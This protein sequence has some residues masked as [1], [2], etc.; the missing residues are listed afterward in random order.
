MRGLRTK[1]DTLFLAVADSEYDV[2]V[3]TETWLDNQILST[4]LFGDSYAVF[5]TDRNPLN[6][7]KLRGGG[8]LIAVSS[9]LCCS[10]EPSQVSDTLEQ[11]W[12]RIKL[13]TCSVSVGVVYIPPDRKDDLSLIQRH[14]DSVSSVLANLKPHDFAFL[15]GDYNHPNMHW[16]TS[17]DGG[18]RSDASL[19]RFSISDSALYD[20]ISFNGLTQINSIKNASARILDL[21]LVNDTA[22]PNCNIA[23]AVESL[24][25]P[26]IAHPALDVVVSLDVPIRFEQ[27]QEIPR[28]DF[29][30]VDYDMMS[31]V[32]SAIDW[33]FLQ[34]DQ[35]MDDIVEHFNSEIRRIIEANVP[36]ERPV[37]KPPWTNN[38]LRKLKRRRRAALRKYKRS[39][40]QQL[41]RNFVVASNKYTSYNRLMY[42]RYVD[43][44]QRNLRSH[45][46]S[47]WSFV[48]SKRKENGLPSSMFLGTLSASTDA[49]KCEL[50]ADR[51]KSAFADVSTSSSQLEAAI[52]DTPADRFDFSIFRITED[53]VQNALRKLKHSTSYGSDGI[54]ACLL[55]KCSNVLARPLATLFNVSLHQ[56][57]F[58]SAWKTSVMTPIHK[59]G[60]KCDMAN[61]R[62]ITSLCAC[63]KL[64]EIIVNDA[65]FAASK[66]YISTAQHGFFPQRSV[67]T[68]LAEFTSVCIRSMDAGMQVDA[69]YTDFKAAFDRVNHAILLR[70]LEKLGVSVAFVGWF[71]SYLSGR[72]IRV[73][74]GSSQSTAF[75]VTS[76]VPQGSNLGP[77]LFSLFINDAAFV[78][79]T[80]TRVFYADDVKIYMI[81][82][83]IED[84]IRLQSLLDS[85]DDWSKRNLLE[86]SVTKCNTITFCRKRQPIV[87]SYCLDGHILE[88][89]YQVRDLGVTLDS[90]LNFRAHYEDII[91]KAN[92]Q[93]GF[94]FKLADG[95]RDPLCL[96]SLYCALVRSILESAVLVWCPYNRIWVDRLES[97]Q[98][99]FVRLALR[100]LPWR[101]RHN[102]P[103]YEHRCMLI[104]IETL[105]KRRSDMQA[106][107]VAKILSN[108][109]D[110]P[111]ILADIAVY[112]PERSLRRRNLLYLAPRNS[113]YGQHD[114]IRFMASRFNEVSHHFDFHVPAHDLL[115]HL[116]NQP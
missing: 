39:G 75:P 23:Q 41:K 33:Q 98:R 53:H 1:I 5:R 88:R 16:T 28:F 2:I 112:V 89:L 107:F 40:S 11:I 10:A 97:V 100:H 76:G 65:L 80:G 116:R 51:F 30:R 105:E 44:T 63:S 92:R 34:D 58:P 111:A 62:G 77:L 14:C 6:S 68:N 37:L 4:Q 17:E 20:V 113:R 31:E 9:R 99:R 12:V 56:M 55:K 81:I 46:K 35:N 21:V 95:F 114:P 26:D 71:K 66:N 18:L 15:F 70:K 74:I 38:R 42:A 13:Q 50:F 96:K 110:A 52:R 59:K 64:F 104:G 90:E 72:F 73:R 22:L 54:P 48:R 103:P 8:V 82:R 106:V 94:I 29:R 84:C 109:V 57:T 60:D 69:V 43:R 67:T 91:S 79:P 61:Y 85:F 87:Y 49:Y 36:L 115:R 83:C 45:P 101:D 93:L 24:V 78:L 27:P 19:S 7:R 47:F 108:E 3:L 25:K 102:L 32:L 86:L